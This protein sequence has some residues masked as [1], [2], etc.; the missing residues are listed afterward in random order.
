MADNRDDARNLFK[1]I[2]VEYPDL[3]EA[4]NN[5]AVLTAYSE[6]WNGAISLLKQA[7]ATNKS[8]QTSYRNLNLIYRYKAA[9]AYR[10]A[11]PEAARMKPSRVPNCERSD[12]MPAPCPRP[13]AADGRR[14]DTSGLRAA[15]PQRVLATPGPG[16]DPG[17][18]RR[19]C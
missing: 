15:Q 10:A 5:L 16:P 2:I 1:N 13:W 9:L 6:D 17:R 14:D 18:P 4:Y 3:P 19:V 8:L 11:L 7:L 12:A